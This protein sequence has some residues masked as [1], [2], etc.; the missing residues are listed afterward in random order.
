LE[1]DDNHR[2]QV[3]KQDIGGV[4]E[5]T[6]HRSKR[7]LEQKARLYAAMK[8]GDV[9]PREN[10][11]ESLIEWD[12]K[13]AENGEREFSDSGSDDGG[14]SDVDRD[15]EVEYEDEFGRLRKG[16]RKD[17]ERMERK[18]RNALLGQEELERMSARPKMPENLIYG[19]TVQVTAFN[20]DDE[21]TTKIEALARKRDRSPTPPPATHYDASGE[22]RSRG[23][24][25]YQFSKDE[26]MREEEMENLEKERLLTEKVR[27]EKEA[28]KE[29]RKKEIEARRRE[30][31]AKRAKKE[32]DSFLDGLA[33]EVIPKIDDA[34]EAGKQEK[35]VES[36]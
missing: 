2:S 13:W 16:T 27:N 26:K 18:K 30:V 35:P 33:E 19:P 28:K 7:K 9:V 20:P 8:R 6:L 29:A 36:L 15:E 23:V 24:G 17:V 22:I 31:L 5:A 34:V 4:D 3:G 10:E 1:G 12:R 21:T 25:F 14:D 11:P 32:A